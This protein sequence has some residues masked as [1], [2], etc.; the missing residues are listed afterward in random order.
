MILCVDFGGILTVTDVGTNNS[1]WRSRVVR[2]IF[3]SM[4]GNL[5]IMEVSDCRVYDHF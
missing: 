3:T 2:N 1:N 4:I 5:F